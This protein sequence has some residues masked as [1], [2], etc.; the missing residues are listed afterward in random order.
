VTAIFAA[1]REGAW[2]KDC[3]AFVKIKKKTRELAQSRRY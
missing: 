1:Q 3:T 2:E